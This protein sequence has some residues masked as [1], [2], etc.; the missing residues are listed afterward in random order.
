[1]ESKN[2]RGRD[3]P[4]KEDRELFVKALEEYMRTGTNTVKCNK[5]GAV[6]RF[7]DHGSAILHDCDCGKFKGTLRGL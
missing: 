7:E 2:Q 5:C 1:M 3:L 4:V 6:I